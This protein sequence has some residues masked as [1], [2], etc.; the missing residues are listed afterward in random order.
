MTIQAYGEQALLIEFE[1]QINPQ[2]NGQ[3]LRLAAAIEGQSWPF[4]TYLIP[5]YCSLTVGFR[6]TSYS[7]LSTA[8]RELWEDLPPEASIPSKRV[9]IP[10]SYRTEHAL[11]KE[12]VMRSTA[13]SWPDIV[14]LHSTTVYRVYMLGFL[15]GFPYLGKL[16]DA[17]KVERLDVPRTRVP[18]LSVGLAGWQTGIYPFEAPGGWLII[19]KAQLPV[20]APQQEDPFLLRAGDEVVFKAVD[21]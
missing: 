10:V 4:V 11:D 7:A 14:E 13:L 18:A 17:L 15:P 20:F 16:P 21:W 8:I 6:Q 5:A 19:G 2:V 9:A 3:V 12:E 1:A